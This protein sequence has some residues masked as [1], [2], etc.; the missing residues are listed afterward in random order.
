MVVLIC[1]SL[2]INDVE[3]L[4]LFF[5]GH[6]YVFFGECLSIYPF[7]FLFHWVFVL[8]FT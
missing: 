1:I 5:F 3:H 8:F 4:F 6:P 7:F 2:V